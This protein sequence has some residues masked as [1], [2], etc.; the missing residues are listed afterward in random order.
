MPGAI[1]AAAVWVGETLLSLGASAA[2][3]AFA[4]AATPALINAAISVGLS[5]GAGLLFRPGQPGQQ[6][7]VTPSSGQQLIRQAVPPRWKS[8][9][10]V[11]LSGP[12]FWFDADV[13][14]FGPT[15]ELYVGVALNQ[16]RID[17][18]VSYHIDEAQVTINGSG[19]VQTAPYNTGISTRIL[20]HLGVPTETA[21][22]QIAS[23]SAFNIANVR[24]DGVASML[25][26]FENFSAAADQQMN[27]PNGAPRFRATINASVVWDPRVAAQN[28]ID[29]T[30]WGWS[31][32]PVICLLNYLLDADG[33]AIPYARVSG[34]LAEWKAAADICDERVP[35]INAGGYEKRYRLALTYLLTDR[36]A[37]VVARFLSTCDGR[38]W[39]KRDGS[40]GVAVGRFVQPTVTLS[41][42]A[43]LEYDLALGQDPLS[44]VAGV[45]ARY[46]S[47][48]HDYRE[49]DAD[50]YPTGAIVME[51][52]D[53]RVASLDLTAVPSH[54]QARRLMKRQAVRE[55]AD[56]RGSIRTTA[57][58]FRAFDQRYIN[59]V[60]TDLGVSETFEV[61]K[62]TFD[63][64]QLQCTLEI[65]S[66]GSEIDAWDPTTEEGTAASQPILIAW[67]SPSF[68]GV[69]GDLSGYSVR[70]II[71]G[72]PI[73][74]SG[75]QVRLTFNGPG[76][77]GGSDIVAHVAIV[78][79]SG[80]TADG[81]T[82]PTEVTFAGAHGYTLLGNQ[83]IT[84][85]WVT[86]PITPGT[87]Y[88]VVA[89]VTSGPGRTSSS[90]DGYYLTAG[91]TTWN[92]ASGG[93]SPSLNSSSD[94]ML[95]TV[96]T[97]ANG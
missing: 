3:A 29:S 59:V 46:M 79:R 52:G 65:A 9:G 30:T 28:L 38:C 31:E 86:F 92:T 60:I 58:G 33:Y 97:R 19:V 72:G 23:A 48:A 41:D 7:T 76:F 54:S 81:T 62:F 57:A 45:R 50:P 26:I 80:S 78:P 96:E 71:P 25:G 49:Q 16:G 93:S 69:T 67:Q 51:L 18:F 64:V 42:S 2:V 87:D 5:L 95:E 47:P 82:T 94:I 1:A 27:Y 84:S 11:R 85:D 35:S 37:D 61:G 36:P 70:Q 73:A 75:D 66:V 20:T 90:G 44:A 34:N 63:P 8:F 21:Y 88:L 24:G 74:V 83:Q 32:N 10:T 14:G 77:G 15:S 91:A 89:D 56:W 55:A 4:V 12:C 22:S 17:S 68:N 13:K 39:Q 43:I 53:E 40:I 6:P